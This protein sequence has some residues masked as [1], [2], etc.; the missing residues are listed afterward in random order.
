MPS[1]RHF[2][3]CRS[4]GKMRRW[5]KTET[6]SDRGVSGSWIIQGKTHISN[7]HKSLKRSLMHQEIINFISYYIFMY[8]HIHTSIAAR[9]GG[10]SFKREKIYNSKEHV[11]IESFVTTLIDWTFVLMTPTKWASVEVMCSDEVMRLFL[12]R[13]M[14]MWCD[15]I[16]CCP[17]LLSTTKYYASTTVLQ[18]TDPVLQSTTPYYKVLLQYYKV[19]PEYYSVLRQHNS[20]LL[21]PVLES[22]TPVLQSTTPV[23]LSTTK[24]Y[25]VLQSTTPELQSTTPVLQSTTPV[26]LQYYQYYPS[27]TPYYKVLRQHN[28][29]LLQY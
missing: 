4:L 5:A 14:F 17:V 29:V 22:T 15:V 26:L 19:L 20:V 18:S 8:H 25:S 28:S 11:P 13:V 16:A 10:G 12:R 3:R 23:L 1:H 27:T 7:V 9:G 24:Y 21:H 2:P 6:S